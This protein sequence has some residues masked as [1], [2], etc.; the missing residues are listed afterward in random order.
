MN[1]NFILENAKKFLI[2]YLKNQKVDY[3]PVHPWR[4]DGI[5][6]VQHSLRVRGYAKIIADTEGLAEREIFLVELASLL[7]DIG[8]FDDRENHTARS[9]T[10]A[11]DWL[12]QNSNFDLVQSEIDLVLGMIEEHSNKEER[13]SNKLCN[14]LKDAD[15]LDEIGVMSILMATHRVDR[16]SSFFH[17][18]LKKKIEE[19][20]IPFCDKKM[21]LCSTQKAK[22]I[23]MEK[24]KF[25]ESFLQ[26]L[27]SETEGSMT[28]E[29]YKKYID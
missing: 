9:R 10:I 20:E 17:E 19:F 12:G 23:I 4:K 8:A 2:N 14:I 28:E 16:G 24:K 6:R 3:E 18:N 11:G 13:D 22:Q 5:F 27:E 1:E 25:I 26:Q 15:I 7:H 21:E 29:E